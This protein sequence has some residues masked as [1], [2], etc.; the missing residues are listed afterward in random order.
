MKNDGCDE[1]IWYH[2]DYGTL[3]IVNIIVMDRLMALWYHDDYDTLGI[4]II[5]VMYMLKTLA[6]MDFLLYSMA[7]VCFMIYSW[8]CCTYHELGAFSV[9]LKWIKRMIIIIEYGKFSLKILGVLMKWRNGI[10]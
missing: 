2:D 5:I 1:T 10:P 4:V 8:L 9:H 3:G 6:F 7:M